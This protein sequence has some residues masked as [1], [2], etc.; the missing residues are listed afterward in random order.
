MSKSN[1]FYRSL[2][3]QNILH[4]IDWISVHSMGVVLIGESGIET[5]WIAKL[6]HDLSSRRNNKFISIDFKKLTSEKILKTLYG[7]EKFTQSGVQIHRGLFENVE[8]GT[9][10]LDNFSYIPEQIQNKIATTFQ[11]KYFRRI[12]GKEEILLN[13]RPITGIYTDNLL[14]LCRITENKR[15]Y[16][17]FCPISIN[18]P[19]LRERKEDIVF[20]VHKFLKE[21]N[22]AAVKSIKGISRKALQIL[23]NY[24]WHENTRQLSKAIDYAILICDDSLIK[25]EHLPMYLQNFAMSLELSK[26]DAVHSSIV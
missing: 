6:I 9:L 8:G 5:D 4:L 22:L 26:D 25:I 15:I 1:R 23:Q 13:V 14:S 3:M 16:S 21:S 24:S 7:Y 20:L 17:K 18:I 19:P 10:F 2:A 12:G 11:N